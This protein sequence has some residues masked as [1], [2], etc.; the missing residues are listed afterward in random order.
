MSTGKRVRCLEIIRKAVA[1]AGEQSRTSS[2]AGWSQ[3]ACSR[4]RN[5]C[6]CRLA[7]PLHPKARRRRTG[8]WGCFR[9]RMCHPTGRHV[10]TGRCVSH[11]HSQASPSAPNLSD[12][13]PRLDETPARVCGGCGGGD[14]SDHRAS[15]G[16]T[17]DLRVRWPSR[18]LLRGICR[19]RRAPSWPCAHPDSNSVCRLARTGMGLRNT[20]G[21]TSHA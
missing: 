11:H 10:R 8:G 12:V 15:R 3:T 21:S 17:E 19:N 7:I 14:C 20:P 6:R 18:L 9:R 4:F 13:R 1:E 5:R 2:A 16:A